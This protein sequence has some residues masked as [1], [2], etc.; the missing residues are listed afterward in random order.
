MPGSLRRLF[1]AIAVLACLAT[2]AQALA[3]RGTTGQ[4]ERLAERT[5]LDLN[6]VLADA[7]AD[8]AAV[9]ELPSVQ[10]QDAAAC[11]SDAREFDEQR[12]T[13]VGAADVEGDIYC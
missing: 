5:I 1:P 9:A 12:Y 4:A 7:R 13:A 2:P 8:L 11:E 6:E 3:A 10:S